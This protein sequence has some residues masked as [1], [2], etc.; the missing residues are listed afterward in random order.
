[1]SPYVLQP[2]KKAKWNNGFIAWSYYKLCEACKCMFW[3]YLY[4]NTQPL[5]GQASADLCVITTANSTDCPG[6]H[7]LP[8]HRGQPQTVAAPGWERGTLHYVLRGGI[9]AVQQ[10]LLCFWCSV[11]CRSPRFQQCPQLNTLCFKYRQKKTE[12]IY[13]HTKNWSVPQPL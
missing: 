1:M 9:L 6:P 13:V 12:K 4:S 3:I 8:C 5:A 10:Q 11:K 7:R 2:Q